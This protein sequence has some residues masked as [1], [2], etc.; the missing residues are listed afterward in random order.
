MHRHH[1]ASG[2]RHPPHG[3]RILALRA[4]AEAGHAARRRRRH[5]AP[6]GVPDAGRSSRYRYRSVDQRG[7]DAGALRPASDL[8]GADQHHQE[9][10]PRR[11]ARCRKAPA[12]AASWSRRPAK[13]TRSIIDVVDNGIGLAEREPHRACS[14]LMSPRARRAPGSASQSSGKI[15]EEHGGGI[16]LHDAADKIA[17]QRGAWVRLHFAVNPPQASA[18]N[19]TDEDKMQACG[20]WAT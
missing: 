16:E 1:R 6:G 19:S 17:G 3:R 15:L 4:H 18:T 20:R 14:S 9:R 2:R 8:A 13:A 10:A 11:S 7:P 12:R 5:R